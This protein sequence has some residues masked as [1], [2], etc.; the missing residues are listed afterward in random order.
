[1][2]FYVAAGQGVS[3]ELAIDGR[4]V[5][6]PDGAS[7]RTGSVRLETGCHAIRVRVAAPYGASRRFE[8]GEIVDDT[9][10]PFDGD[11]IVLTPVGSVHLAWHYAIDGYV[12]IVL[13]WLI[14]RMVG[15]ALRR[16]PQLTEA[17]AA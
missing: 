12:A 14:W 9:T 10:R 7:P 8:A 11:R 4:Q 16:F 13:T 2:T 6:A 1:M 17:P 5:I 3:S 15:R